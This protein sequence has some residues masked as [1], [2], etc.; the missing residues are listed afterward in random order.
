MVGK[1]ID[2]SSSENL[3]DVRDPPGDLSLELHAGDHPALVLAPGFFTLP[4]CA[5]LR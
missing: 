4:G 5:S 2:T 3:W 1:E